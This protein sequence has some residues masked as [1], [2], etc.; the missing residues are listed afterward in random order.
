MLQLEADNEDLLSSEDTESETTATM[1]TEAEELSPPPPLWVVAKGR[2]P[3]DIGIYATWTEAQQKTS[4]VSGADHKKCIGIQEAIT[5]MRAANISDQIIATQTA[6]V[7]KM[8]PDNSELQN[9]E[10]THNTSKRKRN[11]RKPNERPNQRK[12][13]SKRSQQNQSTGTNH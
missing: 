11:P 6:K 7:M 8:D 13:K 5:Y 10:W 4:G 1:G 9:N 3:S 12:H 2:T